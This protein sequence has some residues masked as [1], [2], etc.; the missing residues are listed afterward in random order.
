M[1]KNHKLTTLVIGAHDVLIHQSDLVSIRA[2]LDCFLSGIDTFLNST[3]SYADWSLRVIS[4]NSTDFDVVCRDVCDSNHILYDLLCLNAVTTHVGRAEKLVI[5][6]VTDGSS[7]TTRKQIR[8]TRDELGI[9]F[10]DMVILLTNT[11]LQD[12]ENI[13]LFEVAKDALL[14]GR[15]VVLMDTSQILKV[16]DP[17]CLPVTEMTVLGQGSIDHKFVQRYAKNYSIDSIH[18]IFDHLD[19]ISHDYHAELKKVLPESRIRKLSGRFDALMTAMYSGFRWEDIKKGIRKNPFSE[20][21]GVSVEDLPAQCGNLHPITEP[22]SL[23]SAFAKFDKAANF[24]SGLYRDINWV[25][26]SSSAFAVFSAI[27]GALALTGSDLIWAI[28]EVFAISIVI[29]LVMFSKKYEV[30]EQWLSNRFRAESIRYSRVC[31]PFLL[32]P[33]TMKYVPL[34]TRN[35]EVADGLDDLKLVRRLMIDS[36]LSRP[37]SNDSYIPSDHFDQLKDYALHILEG[38]MNFHKRTAHR[39][40]EIAHN[41]HRM[42]FICFALTGVAIIGHFVVHS[43]YWLLLTAALPALAGAIHGLATQNE[44]ERIGQISIVTYEQLVES[45]S[46]LAINDRWNDLDEAQRFLQMQWLIKDAVD[47]MAG[48]A[49]SWQD[50]VVGRAT[51]LPA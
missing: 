3:S 51:T 43:D 1:K 23:K 10:S 27:A 34:R 16:L 6:P 48:S 41:L 44:F 38:Q 45:H 28:A 14:F 5:Y 20:Y 24:F 17:E 42:S 19:L 11:D 31:L 33:S 29:F 50:I 40:H 39:N 9:C 49:R 8:A 26:Y 37:R 4:G 13:E 32:S 15:L 36:G 35:L 22:D 21:Y 25:V 12:G 46:A 47:V 2:N 7:A 30:H 18:S